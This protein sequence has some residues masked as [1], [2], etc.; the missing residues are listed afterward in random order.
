MYQRRAAAVLRYLGH[1]VR[2]VGPGESAAA[3]LAS[4]ARRAGIASGFDRTAE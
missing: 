4:E 2:F 3:D 1:E